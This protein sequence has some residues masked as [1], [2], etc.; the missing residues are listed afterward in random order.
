MRR[1]LLPWLALCAMLLTATIA[2][3]A[4]KQKKVKPPERPKASYELAMKA[5][6][7]RSSEPGCEPN[8]PEWIM[9]D[10]EI[11]TASPGVFRKVLQQAGKRKLPVVIRSPGGRVT[12]AL[13]IGRMIRKAGLNVA[14][15]W[16]EYA[17]CAPSDK[18]CKL[19][20]DSGGIYRGIAKAN[21]LMFCNSACPFIIMAGNIRLS[22]Y[23]AYVGVHQVRT[24]WTQERI[25]YRERYKIVKGKRKV[26]ERKVTGRKTVKSYETVGLD[27]SLKKKLTAYLKEMGID[28]AFLAEMEKAPPSSLFLVDLPRQLELKLVTSSLDVTALTRNAVCGIETAA[29][30]CVS[31]KPPIASIPAEDPMRFVIVRSTRDCEPLCP[32]WISAQ[33]RITAETPKR[34]EK[35]LASLGDRRLPVVFHS[36]GGDLDA[37]L[38]MGRLIRARGLETAIG[39]TSFVKCDPGRKSCRPD[40]RLAP[41]HLGNLQPTGTCSNTCIFAMAGGKRRFMVAIA[42]VKLYHPGTLSPAAAP[43][44]QQN[45][46]SFLHDMHFDDWLISAMHKVDMYV[47]EQLSMTEIDRSG[48]AED[49]LRTRV[50]ADPLECHKPVPALN[51]VTRN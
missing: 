3:A 31:R 5:V 19:P 20:K 43:V 46:A 37:A 4:T 10:G 33:G 29:Q 24:K 17:G 6:I 1:N 18:A 22:G 12:A 30:N 2:E 15:G 32:E 23:G 8:C 35:L 7:V 16:T 41:A 34:L 9:V 51:C 40:K 28:Q 50:I 48:L 13:E 39:S 27:K 38:A 11:T 42:T 25:Y 45:I 14:V 47:P 21:G 49:H 36:E 44:T 26:L